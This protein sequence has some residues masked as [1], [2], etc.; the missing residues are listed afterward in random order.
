MSPKTEKTTTTKNLLPI[1]AAQLQR[2]REQWGQTAAHRIGGPDDGRAMIDRLGL[3][4]LFPVSPEIP[5]LFHAFMGD[6][7]AQVDSG[8]DSPSGEVYTWRWTLGGQEAAFYG[9]IV[10]NRPTWVSW[11]LLPE[12]LRLR[13]E[14]RSADELYDAGEISAGARRIAEAL[15]AGDGVLSTGEL[16]REAGFPTGKENR[17]AYLKALEELDRR[18][19]VA[20]VFSP[21][22]DNIDMSH[23]LVRTRYP[24]QLATAEQLTRD[25][26]LTRLLRPYLPAAIYVVPTTLAKHLGL[27]EP[28]LRSALDR[29]VETGELVAATL[30]GQRGTCYLWQDRGGTSES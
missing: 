12:I 6:P 13:G 7:E 2:R 26:A 3:V 10:R 14:L 27:P 8:H 11:P 23:A 15:E 30:N 17:A 24:K 19:L 21:T 1:E 28:E 18:L 20:K 29:F 25:E 4:T 22:P 16:R 5:N 9:T